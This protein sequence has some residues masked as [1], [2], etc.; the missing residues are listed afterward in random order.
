MGW[1]WGE[2]LGVAE[3]VLRGLLFPESPAP[4]TESGR[5]NAE[6]MKLWLVGD[7]S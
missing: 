3:R 1:G 7:K 5:G 6:M 4:S 2:L